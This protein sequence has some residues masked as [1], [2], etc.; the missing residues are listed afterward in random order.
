VWHQSEM[1]N[2]HY[3]YAIEDLR[4]LG[5][6]SADVEWRAA[7]AAQANRLSHEQARTTTDHDDARRRRTFFAWLSARR[8][9]QRA[10]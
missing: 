2:D 3:A 10:S 1:L 4:R 7:R 9:A 6:R 8:K 5:P